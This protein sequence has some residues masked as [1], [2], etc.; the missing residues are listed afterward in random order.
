[1]FG[2]VC[3]YCILG[4]GQRWSVPYP[5]Q[6]YSCQGTVDLV[7]KSEVLHYRTHYWS[8]FEVIQAVNPHRLNSLQDCKES[9]LG[10]KASSKWGDYSLKQFVMTNA[11][12]LKVFWIVLGSEYHTY[13]T[14]FWKIL[15]LKDIT[16]FRQTMYMVNLWCHLI[17]M[18]TGQLWNTF[19]TMTLRYDK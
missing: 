10:K 2:N 12:V 17:D 11:G 16:Q 19:V 5:H 6:W 7:I 3:P 1:M 18:L 4:I 13:K 8:R 15:I 9:V 14:C